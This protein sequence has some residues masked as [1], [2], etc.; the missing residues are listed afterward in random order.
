MQA[1]RLCLIGVIIAAVTL[2]GGAAAGGGANFAWNGHPH[3]D[4][5]FSPGDVVEGSTSVWI[6]DRHGLGTPDDEPFF[7][8]LVP[9]PRKEVPFPPPVPEDAIALGQITIDPY[10]QGASFSVARVFF[11]VPDVPPGDYFVIHCD[12][13]CTTTLGDIM[14]TQ[15]IIAAD[16]ADERATI[17]IGRLERRAEE[18]EF[19]IKRMRQQ[20]NRH[21]DSIS[22]IHDLE[23]ANTELERRIGA[24]EAQLADA[25]SSGPGLSAGA[26]GLAAVVGLTALGLAGRRIRRSR[27]DSH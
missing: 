17:G 24:I 3:Y 15:L 14:T 21:A 12:D 11:T 13:P 19:F 7:A 2:V 8:Y 25:P 6:E 10:K 26:V 18:N 5:A 4:V 23:R 16:E 1:A 20:L 27:P 22:R 9:P